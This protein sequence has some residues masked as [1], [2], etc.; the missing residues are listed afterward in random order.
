M[1]SL[2][3]AAHCSLALH[4]ACIL[5]AFVVSRY[6]APLL[7]PAVMDVS[8]IMSGAPAAGA[9]EGAVAQTPPV[10]EK[11][12]GPVSRKQ[13]V[14]TTS[15]PKPRPAATRKLEPA[16]NVEPTQPAFAAQAEQEAKPDA[17]VADSDQPNQ[18]GEA[19]AGAA[20][21][22]SGNPGPSSK[23]GGIVGGLFTT[24]QL[25]GSLIMLVKTPPVYPHS[26]KRRNIE[27]WIKVRFVVD[28]QGQVNRVTVLD[29][30]PEGVFEQSVLRCVASWRFKPGAVG[31]IAVKVLVEQT[32]TFKLEG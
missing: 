17:A 32:I 3:R 16:P 5:C 13:V 19:S 20:A 29:A 11:N 6:A 4:A 18:S 25:D 21:S 9:I 10:K 22:G 1:K 12:V 27:G 24:S 8:I 26:A 23:V 28:E 2:T 30:Q 14:K 31:G 15:M 7:P